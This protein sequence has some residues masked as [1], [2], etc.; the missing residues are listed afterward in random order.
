[1]SSIEL[2]DRTRRI[3]DL[4]HKKTSGRVVFDDFCSLMGSVV[5]SSVCVL[6]AKGKLLGSDSRSVYP[7]VFSGKRGSFIDDSLNDRLL[8]VRSTRENVGLDMLGLEDQGVH[9]TELLITPVEAAGDRLGTIIF[10][11][12]KRSYSVE[13]VILCEYAATVVGL[14]MLRSLKA[15]EE[16]EK[17]LRSDIADAIAALT[18]QEMRAAARVLDEL[19]GDSGLIVASRIAADSGITRSIIVNAIKKLDSAGIVTSRSAGAKGTYIEV[20]N[21]E[22]YDELDR[23]ASED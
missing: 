23:I 6:S 17:R 1:M 21:T 3:G 8:A 2:L 22:I 20:Q 12:K 13:D 15:E 5:P 18:A 11:R 19:P 4:L 14:E 16:S 10:F 7:P 9:E